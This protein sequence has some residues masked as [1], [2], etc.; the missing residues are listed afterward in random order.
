MIETYY[1][2]LKKGHKCR[3]PKFKGKTDKF[4]LFYYKSSFKIIDDKYIRLNVGK[5]FDTIYTDLYKLEKYKKNKYYNIRSLSKTKINK[6]YL[7][8]E[9]SSCYI[10]KCYLINSNYI[11]IKLPKKF[12]NLTYC[13][14]KPYG[15]MYK[16]YFI[17]RVEKSIVNYEKPLESNSISIDLGVKNLMVIYNPNGTQH[18]IKGNYINSLNHFYNKKIGKIQSINKEQHNINISNRIYSLF[19]ERKKKINGYINRLIN[20]LKSMYPKIKNII[21][22]YNKGWK[23]NINLGSKTNRKFYQIPFNKIINKMIEQFR[24][25]NIK[26]IKTEESYT[27]K[28]D[29]LSL[30][31]LGKNKNYLGN[32][33][34]RGLFISAIGKAINADLNGAINIMRKKIKLKKINGLR[35]FNP[36]VVHA[37]PMSSYIYIYIRIVGKSNQFVFKDI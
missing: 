25:N 3:K 37:Q 21:I 31:K 10:N 35:L 23:N 1:K 8:I 24:S 9:N 5:Y 32:R 22:G 28:C 18:I 4:N 20:K 29:A 34:N 11:Y 27:S 19:E 36:T 12:N 7:K 26:I 14:I 30:E 6:N 33:K 16:I 17:D 13:E 2:T 15:N